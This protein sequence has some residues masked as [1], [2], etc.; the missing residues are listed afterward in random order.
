M[1][2]NCG[3]KRKLTIGGYLYLKLKEKPESH[4][5]NFITADGCARLVSFFTT[6]LSVFLATF[7]GGLLFYIIEQRGEDVVPRDDCFTTA[8]TDLEKYDWSASFALREVEDCIRNRSRI[9]DPASGFIY[10]W[11]LYTTVGYGNTYP[12]TNLGRLLTMLFILFWVPQFMTFKVEFGRVATKFVIGSGK[13]LQRIWFRLRKKRYDSSTRPLDSVLACTLALFISIYFATVTYIVKIIE[14]YDLLTSLYLLFITVFLVGLGDVVPSTSLSTFLVLK[15]LFLLG[16]ALTSYMNYY[17]HARTRVW[18]LR[19]SIWVSSLTDRLGKV[20]PTSSVS[21]LRD[22]CD[23]PVITTT[24]M[25]MNLL[26]TESEDDD[27]SS[28]GLTQAPSLI[29]CTTQTSSCKREI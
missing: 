21:N 19:W 10:A 26:N 18:L 23:F 4:D 5:E 7:L 25:P 12:H 20:T 11:S 22:D 9:N 3:G 27:L 16:D 28:L 6:F 1:G 15:P 13:Y 29:S 17:F 14:G 24:S 8:H 2:E